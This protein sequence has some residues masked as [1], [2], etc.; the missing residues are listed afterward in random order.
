[1]SVVVVINESVSVLVTS[2][3]VNH[4][5]AYCLSVSTSSSSSS[6]SPLL[7]WAVWIWNKIN[8]N[9]STNDD[10][11]VQLNEDSFSKTPIKT[12]STPDPKKRKSPPPGDKSEHKRKK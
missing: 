7:E 4:D 2:E 11:E 6:S 10:E 12:K 9:D 1:M 5:E 3:Y 8:A